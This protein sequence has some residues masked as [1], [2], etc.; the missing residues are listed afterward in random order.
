LGKA[1]GHQAQ[2]EWDQAAEYFDIAFDQDPSLKPHL[3]LPSGEEQSLSLESFTDL[4]GQSALL[5]EWQEKQ[6]IIFFSNYTATATIFV[7]KAGFYQGKISAVNSQPG[8]IELSIGVDGVLSEFLHYDKNDW[9][10]DEKIF[11]LMLPLGF[12]HFTIAFTNDILTDSGLDRNA[13]VGEIRFLPSRK[14]SQ[15]CD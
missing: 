1:L 7:E 9:S 5:T 14:A 13:L 2:G 6:V 10:W 11:C 15:R 12:H 4:D 8:P 3:V